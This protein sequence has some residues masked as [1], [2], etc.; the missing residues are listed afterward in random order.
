MVVLVADQCLQSTL[1]DSV[2]WKPIL[3]VIY[4]VTCQFPAC[5]GAL[6]QWVLEGGGGIYVCV[7]KQIKPQLFSIFL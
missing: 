5:W 4:T 2:P 3:G 6:K 7:L 1:T